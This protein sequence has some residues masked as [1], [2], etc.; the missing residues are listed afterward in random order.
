VL[1]DDLAQHLAG[2]RVEI[3]TASIDMLNHELNLRVWQRMAGL[4]WQSRRMTANKQ[5]NVG[6]APDGVKICE[7]RNER[8]K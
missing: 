1:H 5:E 8:L 4:V 7:A 6:I 2:A 3:I